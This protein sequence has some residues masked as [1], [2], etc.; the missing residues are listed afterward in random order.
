M[1]IRILD[2][3][4]I[5]KIS[6]GEVVERP[7]SAAKELIENALDAGST[8]ITVEV[9]DGDTPEILQRRVMEQ[10]EWK[11]LPQAV[12]LVSEEIRRSR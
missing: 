9:K 3:A 7:A 1:P 10:A 2:A 12:E 4:T 6:A 5:G 8:A 11:L